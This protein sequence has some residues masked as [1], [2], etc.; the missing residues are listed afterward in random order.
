M[1]ASLW[2]CTEAVSEDDAVTSPDAGSKLA[3]GSK[4]LTVV[5]AIRSFVVFRTRAQVPR[6]DPPPRQPFKYPVPLHD[7]RFPCS[8]LERE[9]IP[10]FVAESESPLEE[11]NKDAFV[12]RREK[13]SLDLKLDCAKRF[14]LALS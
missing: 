4:L 5:Q 3:S 14:S 9:K 2:R 12:D 7:V 11:F 8:S 6:K 10:T 13:C 1:I